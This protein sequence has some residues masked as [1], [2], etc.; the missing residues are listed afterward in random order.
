MMKERLAEIVQNIDPALAWLWLGVVALLMVG[1]YLA[2]CAI[3]AD[4][5]REEIQLMREIRDAASWADPAKI[6]V[7][8]EYQ[9]IIFER[10]NSCR[11]TLKTQSPR[12]K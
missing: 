10:R 6:A 2:L 5:E 1:I 11:K 3:S 9:P 8:P 12:A 7:I 4:H